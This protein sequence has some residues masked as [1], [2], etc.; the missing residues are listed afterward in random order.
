MLIVVLTG[1]WNQV[2]TTALIYLAGMQSISKELYESA[3]IDGA[4]YWKQTYHITWKMIA[5]ALTI[6]MI[7]LLINSLKAYDM[8]AILTQ[9]G[10]GTA[11][12]VINI[13][14]LN[15]SVSGYKVGLG[16]AMSM[17]VTIFVFI[18]VSAMNGVL[19]KREV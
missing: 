12:K 5:P 7:F 10:P 3:K 1:V 6:N 9:G 15:Y 4:G 19:R 14:I 2:G 13:A 11:T 16:A 18:I 17:V 8:I